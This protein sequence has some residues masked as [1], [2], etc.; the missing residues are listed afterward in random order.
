MRHLIGIVAVCFG[1]QAVVSAQAP[2]TAFEL[3]TSSRQWSVWICV[4][5]SGEPSSWRFLSLPRGQRET[6]PRVRASRVGAVL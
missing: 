1:L 2:G 4:D 3:N 6:L 5:S